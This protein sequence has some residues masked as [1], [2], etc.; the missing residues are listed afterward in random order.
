MGGAY[1]GKGRDVATVYERPSVHASNVEIH[2][3]RTGAL[4]ILGDARL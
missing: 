4:T 1:L 3:S 2:Q